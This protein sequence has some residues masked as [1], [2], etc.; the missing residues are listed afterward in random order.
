MVGE[1]SLFFI[2]LEILFNFSNEIAQGYFKENKYHNDTHIIDSLQAMHYLM[3]IGNL[4]AQ[5]KKLDIFSVFVANI[6]HDFEHPG[7]SN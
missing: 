6:I 7:Y 2:P 1:N 4:K 3:E 5:V